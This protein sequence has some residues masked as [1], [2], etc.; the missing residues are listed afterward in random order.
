[1]AQDPFKVDQVQ[2]EP[3]SGTT[4]LIR[5]KS[6]SSPPELEFVDGVITG[7][8]TL[9]SM[10]SLSTIPNVYIV[11]TSGAGAEY[12]TIQD[13]LDDIPVGASAANPYVVLVMSGVYTETVNLVRDGVHIIGLGRVVIANDSDDDHTLIISAQDGTIPLTVTL[14]NLTITNDVNAKACVRIS[15]GAGSTLGSGLITLRNCVLEA[16]TTNRTIWASSCNNLLVDGG[17]IGG[18]EMDLFACYEVAQV[19]V[20]NV[21]TMGGFL[22]RWDT[23]ESLP[24]WAP[25]GCFVANCA[26]IGAG[27]DLSPPVTVT[28]EDG[29]ASFVGC[30]MGDVTISGTQT[31]TFENCSVRGTL[32]SQD[33]STVNCIL[34]RATTL[35]SAVG[36]TV[37]PSIL[38]GTASF[39]GTSSEDVAFDASM[40]DA[41]YTVSLTLKGDSGGVVP[42]VTAQLVSGFTIN[43]G[44]AKTL[45]VDWTVTRQSH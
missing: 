43:F 13:A 16:T 19:R 12:T 3:G 23:G 8:L 27:S 41:D 42:W 39:A 7:G 24:S 18:L 31:V 9:S 32:S 34:T 22:Y 4:I 21:H 15:G 10:A 17:R 5:R 37:T 25:V 14:E 36:A 11:G 35:T 2:I 40:S 45:D 38:T 20:E 6:S 28:L 44:A 1:M 29:E 26:N 30:G 33:T